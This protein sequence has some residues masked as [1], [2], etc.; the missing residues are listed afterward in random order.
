VSKKALAAAALLAG[1]L[2]I[3][4]LAGGGGGGRYPRGKGVFIDDLIKEG[5]NPDHLIQRLK[6][7]GISW[8]AVEIAWYGPPGPVQS[9]D[10]LGTTHNLEDG[11]L[12]AFV[13][14]LVAAG[15]QVWVWGFPSPD[16]QPQF[17]QNVKDA[18][19]VAPQVAGTILDTEKPYYGSQHG[20]ALEDLIAQ[21][22]ALGKPVGLTSYGSPVYHPSFPWEV[23][24]G[25]DFGMP[26]V[27]SELGPDY[28]NRAD[29]EW[30]Q[31]GVS[32]IVP[33]N[34]ATA[35]HTS[36]GMAEQA[37]ASDTSDGGI[38]W[39]DYRA[40]VLAQDGAQPSRVEFVR[41]FDAWGGDG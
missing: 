35:I 1:G 27:Y 21:V 40:L 11:A 5:Q 23:I 38:G 3:A 41:A 14:E 19:A 7:L 25:V 2:G 26:Q 28:P 17:I 9:H 32:P 22:K 29:D 34:G 39:F 15:I 13:P 33:L 37:A 18:Y 20:P 30:R 8:V 6:Y 12:A 24:G 16:R 10:L 36:I 4:L 31:L